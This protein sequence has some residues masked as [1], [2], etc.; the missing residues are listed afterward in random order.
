MSLEKKIMND[1]KDAM[2]AKDTIRLDVCRAIKSEI[3]ILKTQKSSIDLSEDKEIQILQKLL[4]QRKESENI[5]KNQGRLDLAKNEKAQAD[6][7]LT[8]LPKPYNRDELLVLI[9]QL[10]IQSGINSR[11]DMGKLITLVI[12]KVKGRSDGKM[13]SDC[14]KEKLT[15]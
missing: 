12:Q 14:V 6:I 13:I 15:V 11:K 2:L 3:L 7:L 1:I 10:M 8:Y 9:D 5:F 4:K